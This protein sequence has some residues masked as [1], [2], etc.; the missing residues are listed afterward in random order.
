MVWVHYTLASGPGQDRTIRMWE[1][2]GVA[3]IYHLSYNRVDHI[4]VTGR[5]GMRKLITVFALLTWV[6][7]SINTTGVAVAADEQPTQRLAVGLHLRS[8][9]WTA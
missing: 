5:P 9:R 2:I 4:K 8:Q 7:F 3:W 6:G 1:T